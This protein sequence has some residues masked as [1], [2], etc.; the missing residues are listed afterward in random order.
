MPS[1]IDAAVLEHDDRSESTT[2]DSRCA[3]TMSVRSSATAS[4]ASRIMLLVDAVERRRRLVEQQDRGRG[5]QGA[6]DREAL[7]LAAREHDAV[8]ADRGVE[9]RRVAIEHLAE[10]HRAQHLLALLVGR[11]GD[12]ELQVVA[13]RAGQHRGVLLDVADLRAQL[14][15]GRASAGRGRR[16]APRRRSGRRSAR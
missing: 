1:P 16:C 8:L 12:A 4:I 2:V 14:A 3:I 11:V 13:Q 6:G 9:A 10:V 15:R 5:E 7:A